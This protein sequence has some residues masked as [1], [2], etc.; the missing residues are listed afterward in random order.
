MAEDVFADQSAFSIETPVKYESIL[1]WV[2]GLIT[3]GF[4]H[5]FLSAETNRSRS[6]SFFYKSFGILGFLHI[7]FIS[8]N[9][10]FW[11]SKPS[12]NGPFIYE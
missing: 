1:D 8:I 4:L 11:K 12:Q 7:K 9:H 6:F 10:F 2:G 3:F 5:I